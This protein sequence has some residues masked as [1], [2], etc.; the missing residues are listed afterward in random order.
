MD[1]TN[2]NFESYFCHN[3]KSINS[4]FDFTEEDLL[5]GDKFQET[6]RQKFLSQHRM[7]YIPH[8]PL[9]SWINDNTI[10]QYMYKFGLPLV[11]ATDGGV[12]ADKQHHVAAIVIGI[13][14]PL[15]H[16]FRDHLNIP[17]QVTIEQSLTTVGTWLEHEF[18]FIS[19]SVMKG[20]ND[21]NVS[22][23]NPWIHGEILPLK[24]RI[25]KLPSHI[26][27]HEVTCG[28]AEGMALNMKE[29]TLPT[30]FPFL[31]IMDSSDARKR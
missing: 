4:S 1:Y 15:L 25:Y 6:F 11:V 13:P 22:N 28:Q 19:Q 14:K 20:S 26:G 2:S 9:T 24:A 7:N 8:Q 10:L 16:S 12:S 5:D 3:W 18:N 23:W 21:N 30:Y 17:I 27:S 31:S 29:E